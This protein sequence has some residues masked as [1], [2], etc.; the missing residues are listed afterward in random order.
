LLCALISAGAMLVG[1]LAVPT[2]ASADDTFKWA[3]Q[4]SGPQGPGGRDYFVLNLAPGQQVVDYVGVSNF[5]DKPIEFRV[6]ATDAF[7]TKDGAFSLLPADKPATD[8]GTWIGFNSD[9]YTVPAGK[10]LDIPFQLTIPA[11]AS[12]GDHIGGI[13]ASVAAEETAGDGSQRITV[14]RRVG[15]RMYLR[16]DGPAQPALK[17]DTIS[18]KHSGGAF[19]PISGGTTTVTYQVTN[20]GNVRLGANAQVRLMAPFGL[21]VG[22]TKASDI[23]ELLPRSSMTVTETFKGVPSAGRLSAKVTLDP[24]AL[25]NTPTSALKRVSRSGSVWAMPWLA[26]LALLVIAAGVVL[27]LRRRKAKL[28]ELAKL[29]AAAAAATAK[30]EAPTDGSAEHKV[31]TI[32]EPSEAADKSVGSQQ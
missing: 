16:V 25:D 13:V 28:A 15:A 27:M 12:P 19:N 1:L 32:P 30:S 4:P 11:D 26:I 7:T 29:K 20:V 17:V 5:S 31:I 10:R 24:V 22:S 14:D 8:V 3:V 2:A 6:Y 21:Q 18:I 9:T 23:K